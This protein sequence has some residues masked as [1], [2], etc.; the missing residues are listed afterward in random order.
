MSRPKLTV[1]VREARKEINLQL[2]KG[3][4]IQ[5]HSIVSEE[6]LESINSQRLLWHDETK[7][8]LESIDANSVL[9]AKFHYLTTPIDTSTDNIMA[10]IQEFKHN[11]KKDL[12][13]LQA[14]YNSLDLIPDVKIGKSSNTSKKRST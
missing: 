3:K 2:E 4:A 7:N 6:G 1:S 14:I 10:K 13:N 5:E 9:V 12:Y 11:M 8:L